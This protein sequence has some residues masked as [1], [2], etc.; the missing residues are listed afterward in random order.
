[1]AK[2]QLRSY[3]HYDEAMSAKDKF[4]PH[5]TT[6]RDPCSEG[7]I[8]RCLCC[9]CWYASPP[10]TSAKVLQEPCPMRPIP[11]DISDL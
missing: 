2:N 9:D 8:I 7:A 1:M 3:F 11:F 4:L 10:W 5:T 6:E